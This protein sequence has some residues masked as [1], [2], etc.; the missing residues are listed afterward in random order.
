MEKPQQRQ[1][2][3]ETQISTWNSTI[4]GRQRTRKNFSRGSSRRQ[5]NVKRPDVKIDGDIKQADGERQNIADIFINF[6]VRPFIF[7]QIS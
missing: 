1:V 7:N 6:N 2:E 5:I 3:Q 4:G